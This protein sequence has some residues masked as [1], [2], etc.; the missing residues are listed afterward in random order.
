MQ[1][2]EQ[3]SDQVNALETL[4]AQVVEVAEQFRLIAEKH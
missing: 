3:V 4:R 2:Q 1:I